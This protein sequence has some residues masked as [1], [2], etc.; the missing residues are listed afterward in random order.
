MLVAGVLL[1]LNLKRHYSIYPEFQDPD[2]FWCGWPAQSYI[3]F[4]FQEGLRNIIG[5]G[6]FIG[7]II[8]NI[9]VAIAILTMTAF[10]MEH[11]IIRKQ[12]RR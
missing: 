7:P 12:K 9:F 11:F 4:P 8:V 3:S 5:P 1:Y 10:F 2:E 6:F